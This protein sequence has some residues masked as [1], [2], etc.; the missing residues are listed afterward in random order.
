MSNVWSYAAPR[1]GV[2][3][4]RS[5]EGGGAMNTVVEAEADAAAPWSVTVTLR[6]TG[7]R[8]LSTDAGTRSVALLR[9]T[10]S[11]LYTTLNAHAYVKPPTEVDDDDEGNASTVAS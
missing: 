8:V 3:A 2:T 9:S 4:I 5:I 6:T 11:S 1:I 10:L 7:P